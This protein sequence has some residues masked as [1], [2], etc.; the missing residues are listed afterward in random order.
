MKRFRSDY[1]PHQGCGI[2]FLMVLFFLFLLSI[3]L[4]TFTH[5]IFLF[6]TEKQILLT[7]DSP[8]ETYHIEISTEGPSTRIL[9]EEGTTSSELYADIVK[10]GLADVHSEDLEIHWLSDTSAEIT[11]EGRR[12]TF[13]YFLFDADA[14][15]KIEKIP[16]TTSSN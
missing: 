2:F 16:S 1:V 9:I 13:H 12:D 10:E 3:P 5:N 4:V 11:V 14:E 8:K 7:S 15:Q 6:Y